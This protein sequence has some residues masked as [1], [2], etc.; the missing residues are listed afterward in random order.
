M[1]ASSAP[2]DAWPMACTIAPKSGSASMGTWPI[3]SC[4]TSGS[5]VYIGC[6]AWRTYCGVRVAG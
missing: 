1:V 2:S 6:D 3:S 5:G 4:T